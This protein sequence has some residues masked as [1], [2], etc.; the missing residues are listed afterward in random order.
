MPTCASKTAGGSHLEV[1]PDDMRAPNLQLPRCLSIPRQ[2]LPLI[3]HDA[4]VREER[5]P[6]LSHA[7]PHLLFL[8]QRQ[9][10]PLHQASVTSAMLV[11]QHRLMHETVAV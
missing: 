9:L 10:T 2:L 5:R 3:I 1:C 6:P 8:A 4:H 7:P 11:L